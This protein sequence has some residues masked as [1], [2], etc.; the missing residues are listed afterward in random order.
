MAGESRAGALRRIAK[1]YGAVE[2]MHSVALRQASAAVQEADGALRAE[3]AMG[4]A[5]AVAGRTA[6]TLGEREDWLL[7][8]A[9]GEVAAVRSQRLEDLR[10][11][12]TE[13]E[14]VARVEFL[15]S[16]V[17]T[18]QMKQVVAQ[19]VELAEIEEGRRFQAAADDRYLARQRWS[20]RRVRDHEEATG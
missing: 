4:S 19:M 17:K 6:L 5:A 12:R 1:L 13:V 2:Q 10:L 14:S 11:Q 20:V 18:E 8:H 15:Q 7:S 3:R 16:R 9:Q